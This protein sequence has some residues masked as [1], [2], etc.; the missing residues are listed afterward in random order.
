[1]K[2]TITIDPETIPIVIGTGCFSLLYFS[3]ILQSVGNLEL[4][5]SPRFRQSRNHPSPFGE[6]KSQTKFDL[7]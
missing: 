1:M 4:L 5:T 2:T 3:F 7:G 6:G